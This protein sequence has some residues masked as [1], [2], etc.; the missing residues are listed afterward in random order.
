M[1]R[2]MAGLSISGGLTFSE[3][4]LLEDQLNPNIRDS[5]SLGDKGD[6]IPDISKFSASTSVDYVWPVND[7]FDGMLRLDYSYIGKSYSHFRPTNTYYEKQGDFG[8]VNL[9]T[10]LEGPDWGAYVFVRNVFDIYGAYSVSSGAGSEQLVN[11]TQP[12][13]VGVNLRKSF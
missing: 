6:Q 8:V 5:T 7:A 1:A 9:R 2:P 11:S 13:T 4:E 12:R 10:G 3:P